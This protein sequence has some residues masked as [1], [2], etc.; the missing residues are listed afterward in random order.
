MEKHSRL[1]LVRHGQVMGFEE[2]RVNG[3]TNVDITETGLLQMEEVAKRLRHAEIDAVY[4]S[5]LIRAERGACIIG[6]HHNRPHH[7]K[8]ELREIFFGDWEGMTFSEIERAYPGE[9]EKRMSDLVNYRPPG[10]GESMGDAAARV[11]RCISEILDE[12]SGKNILLVAHGGINRLILCHALGLNIS[13]LF[14][15][16]QDFG[17]LNI[18]DFFPDNNAVVRLMNG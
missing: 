8:G 11:I 1:Y 17:C 12:H 15:I 16:Q 14:N 9:I 7:K 2:T 10:K 6:R 5:D 4:S 18:I 13:R 3:H